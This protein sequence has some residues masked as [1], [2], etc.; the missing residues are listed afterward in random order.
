MIAAHDDSSVKLRRI[1]YTLLIVTSA[2]TMVG[3]IMAVESKS[4][5]T[6]MLSANDRSRWC[7]IRSLV[8]HG[9]YEIDDVIKRKTDWYTIDMVRHKGT[10]GREH[11]YSSKPPLLATLLAGEYWG[12]QV[13]GGSH[14]DRQSVLRGPHHARRE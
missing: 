8:D 14:A 4:G 2:A 11:F 6:A 13:G 7:T 9:T 3:R 12:A 1:V 5:K 10:D